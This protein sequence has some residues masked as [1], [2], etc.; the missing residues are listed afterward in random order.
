MAI[1]AMIFI[2]GCWLYK[3]R[4]ALFN[5]LGEK[6]F[7]VDYKRIPDIIAQSL[8]EISGQEVD[9]VRTCYYGTIPVNKLGY[10]PS[11]QK[12][13]YDFLG[14]QCGYEMDITEIDFR[15]EPSA[16]PDAKWVNANLASEMTWFATVPGAYDVA[17]LVAGD[18]DYIP[19]LRRV[20]RLGK[21]VQLV[22]MNA[23]RNLTITS[24][25]L[26]TAPNCFDY[27][28]I[29]MDEHAMDFRLQR[30]MQKRACMSCGKEEETTWGG[31][32]FF[33]A[34][35]RVKRARKTRTCDNCGKEEETT[36]DKDFF[37]CSECR[38]KYR[39]NPTPPAEEE[40][41]FKSKLAPT[42]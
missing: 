4:Q 34:E 9:I 1:R 36:W 29:Y 21:R 31:D 32:E 6:G 20:R 14:E 27:P 7:E 10:N 2:D 42:E 19:V 8:A 11:K 22:A 41:K 26:L 13:F 38:A 3:G 5:R 37:Y 24:K 25:L 35:C 17:V 15:C 39:S 40:T 16:L 18:A 12:V 28:H 30:E 33:C 23:Q